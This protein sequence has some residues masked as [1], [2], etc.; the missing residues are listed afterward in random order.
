[1]L[2][3]NVLCVKIFGFLGAV[4]SSINV[5]DALL[6]VSNYFFLFF[7]FVFVLKYLLI[8]SSLFYLMKKRSIKFKFLV[9]IPIVNSSYCLGSLSDSINADYFN[10]TKSR[11]LLLMLKIIFLCSNLILIQTVKMQL[12]DFRIKLIQF[13][14]GD[15]YVFDLIKVFYSSKVACY[16][17]LVTVVVAMIYLIY[18]FK[19][20]YNVYS[21]YGGAASKLMLL[22]AIF[23]Y[24]FFKFYFLPDLFI[25][26]IKGRFSKIEELNR[27]KN[28]L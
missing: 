12:P 25:Y 2:E 10:E 21:E 24:L 7:L 20:Y 22:G 16:V 26:L 5:N 13:I 3:L 8:A 9:F 18:L 17:L 19:T 1:M 28:F 11:F 4:L 15:Y 27:V 6:Q 23:S 14:L